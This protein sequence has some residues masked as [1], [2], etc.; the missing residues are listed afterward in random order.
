M[1]VVEINWKPDWKQLR[2]FG[3]VCLVAFGAIGAWLFFM[4][5]LLGFEF[6]A[7]S[8]TRAAYVLW[9]LA[10]VC[11]LLGLVAPKLLR[12]LYVG[13]MLISFPIG[14]V[15]SHVIMALLFYGLFT[16]IALIFRL[17]GRDAL[18][19]K[20]EPEATT[21]WVPHETGKEVK[22]YYRQF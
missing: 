2:G 3:W 15:V 6:G 16:P 12:P 19:R 9:A 14:F 1:A 22:R 8:A 13:L 4:H 21:Y 11:A 5:S 18:N 10:A 17:I 20:F 7:V